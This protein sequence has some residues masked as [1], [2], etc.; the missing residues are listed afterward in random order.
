MQKPLKLI[1]IKIKN[2]RVHPH[3]KAPIVDLKMSKIDKK[4]KVY[5]IRAEYPRI[6]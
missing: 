2:Q 5:K 3:K 4:W 1:R 6:T